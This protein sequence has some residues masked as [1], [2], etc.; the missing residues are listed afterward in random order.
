MVAEIHARI[1]PLGKQRDPRR[2]VGAFELD[3]VV[4]AD[5]R[6]VMALQAGEQIGGERPRLAD[7]AKMT[8]DWEIVEGERDFAGVNGRAGEQQDR[9]QQAAQDRHA[10]T[11]ADKRAEC[12]IDFAA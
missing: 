1:E 5:R 6:E 3:L 2:L 11:M 12:E 9:E 8:I 10:A 4:E 7:R